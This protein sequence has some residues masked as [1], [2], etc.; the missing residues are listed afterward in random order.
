MTKL[1]LLFKKSKTILFTYIYLV[2][3][4]KSLLFLRCEKDISNGVRLIVMCVLQVG[5]SFADEWAL[6][7]PHLSVPPTHLW[8]WPAPSTA[9]ICLTTSLSLLT[10]DPL[11]FLA[12]PVNT[13]PDPSPTPARSLL[14]Q[15]PF[16]SLSLCASLLPLPH[17]WWA[18]WCLDHV[19]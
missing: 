9:S 13:I 4:L 8:P 12:S 7:W 16:L 5:C 17:S 1:Y 14:P 2:Y 15:S 10:E 3:F 19:A 18:C 11:S 6:R